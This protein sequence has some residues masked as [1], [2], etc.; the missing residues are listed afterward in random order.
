[1][2]YLKL[3]L[4]LCNVSSWLI[5][6]WDMTLGERLIWLGL[7]KARTVSLLISTRTEKLYWLLSN[8]YIVWPVNPQNEVVSWLDLKHL[9]LWLDT[10]MIV[11]YT[12]IVS[13]SSIE[14][15]GLSTTHF[16]SP[17]HLSPV[18]SAF[19]FSG[20]LCVWFCLTFLPQTH[21]PSLYGNS[22]YGLFLQASWDIQEGEQLYLQSLCIVY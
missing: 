4:Q 20:A 15:A 13:S 6:V 14:T 5:T 18:Q 9:V 11:A 22:R 3:C 7:P 19:S 12:G 17:I 1:M 2:S 10:I 16:T 8:K 21:S